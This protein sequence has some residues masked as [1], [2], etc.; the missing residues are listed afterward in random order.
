[1]P[2]SAQELANEVLSNPGAVTFLNGS[3]G[4]GPEHVAAGARVDRML[5]RS[6]GPDAWIEVDVDPDAEAD[7]ITVR[8][9]DGVTR[10]VALGAQCSLPSPSQRPR[11]AASCLAALT[12]R[13]APARRSPSR[14]LPAAGAW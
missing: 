14:E 11:E 5:N 3:P 2:R 7:M 9:A 8:G 12:R 4:D 6:T 1:M 13:L 10:V